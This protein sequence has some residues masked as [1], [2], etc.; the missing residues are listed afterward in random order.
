[1]RMRLLSQLLPAA[2]ASAAAV[3]T[4]TFAPAARAQQPTPHLD[5]LEVPGGPQDGIAA[6]R[7][8][9][10]QLPIVYGQ[11]A[12]GYSLRPLR[13]RTIS[14][15]PS[16]IRNSR[17]SVV[18]DQLS[19]YASAGFQFLDRISVGATLPFTP[20]QTGGN[21]DYSG[22]SLPGTVTGGNTTV[23][24]SGPSLSDLRL[25]FRGVV[26][27]SDDRKSAFGAQVSVFAPSG[28]G[29]TAN[30]G[31]EGQTHALFMVSGET[32]VKGL[33]L[34]ANTGIHFK[35]RHAINAPAAGSGLGTGN[36]WRWALAAFVPFK[37]G[38][39]R[40]GATIFGQTGI[41]SD[42]LIG[43]TFFTAQNTPIEWQAE[44][45]MR[46]GGADRWW[47]GAGLGTRL[48]GGY[49]APDFR[50][51]A[52][53]G[54]SV[55]ILESDASS[56]ERKER[57]RAKWRAEGSSRDTDNDGIPDDI[58]ACPTE[59]EDHQGMEP[60]DGCPMPPDKDGD[61]IPDSVDKCP[62]QAEDKDGV[63]DGDG[64]PEDDADSDGVPD[65]QDAC[66]KEPGPRAPD[67]KK[68]GC[69]SFYR[70]DG[71]ML[72]LNEQVH[73]ANGS[74][75]ILP[76]S[77]PM[78]NEIATL[79]KSNP[80]LKKLGIEGHTDNHGAADMNKKLSQ[81][82]ADAVKKYIVG[83]GVEDGR[84]EAAGYGLERPI[85]DNATEKGR[86]ANRRVEFKILE[87]G[88]H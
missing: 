3:V 37:D 32:A 51:V 77:F 68:N 29:S 76:Q 61:G 75:N 73:F 55:P 70:V 83:K 41:E 69:P 6:F 87:E 86:F 35:P 26:A 65:A 72:K 30:F 19:V 74:A 63:D 58:D 47:L 7:P 25:D 67:P 45:R 33:V 56:P 10:D 79:M 39:Y 38:K 18:Q 42:N 27:R 71:G 4:L 9:T 31:G 36:E 48:L 8:Q 52:L 49:G 44:G 59:P 23:V 20:F 88:K 43:D 64:C 21:P 1:M 66:P 28:N 81:A 80:G 84:L 12:I 78:L 5:R 17:S 82:R 2:A 34:V 24:T 11:L 46:F 22:G 54:T 85:E 53:I 14:T 15:D 62:D 50:M 40:L 57:I 60:G 13:T 16:V